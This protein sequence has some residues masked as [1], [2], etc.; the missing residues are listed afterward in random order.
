MG[1]P[2][3]T[4]PEMTNEWISIISNRYIELYEKLIGEKFIPQQLSDK[5]TEQKI[6]QSLQT[7]V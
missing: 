6:N 3:Q 7:L 5:E 4:L 2:G 1:Q